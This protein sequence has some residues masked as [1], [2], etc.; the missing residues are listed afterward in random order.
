[1]SANVRGLRDNRKRKEMFT[2][3]KKQG[4][5]FAFLQEVHSSSADEHIWKNEWGNC[6]IFSHGETDA[7]G[8]CILINPKVKAV[9]VCL[10]S[11]FD[12]GRC[13]IVDVE[14]K[15]NMYTLINIYAP[16]EDKPEFFMKVFDKASEHANPDKIIAG[17]FNLVLDEKLDSF[18]RKQNNVKSAKLVR[19]YNDEMQMIDIFRFKNPDTFRFTYYRKKPNDMY[20]R[21]DN[22]L[23]NYAL[24]N[25]VEKCEIL[26]G[27]KSDHSYVVTDFKPYN[28][29][30]RGPGYWK[31]NVSILHELDNVNKIN[32]VIENAK[33]EARQND[34]CIRWEHVKAEC[35]RECKDLSRH[36]MSEIARNFEDCKIRLKR[37]T[38]RKHAS[39]CE[40]ESDTV[41]NQIDTEIAQAQSSI[42]RY[43]E[44]KAQ[45]A[46]IRSK[47]NWYENAEKGTK[48]FLG[49]EKTKSSN[50]TLRKI[51]AENGDI[52]D[53]DDEILSELKNFYGKLYSKDDHVKFQLEN[54]KGPRLTEEQKERLDQPLTI[55]ELGTSLFEMS[56][57]KAPGL[58]GLPC[59]F[60]KTFFSKLKEILFEA[61]MLSYERGVLYRSARRG[62]IS[63][64][65]KKSD[66]LLLKNWRP[67]SLCGVDCKILT[68]AIA[69][70]FKSV[71]KYIIGNQQTVYIPG[72]FIGL[73]IRK[74]IDLLSYLEKEEVP[75]LLI[76]IDFYKCFDSISHDALEGVMKYFNFGEKIIAWVRLIYNQFELCTTNNGHMSAYIR[77]QRGV[78]Q[79]CGLSGPLFLLSAELLAINFKE[80]SKIKGIKIGKN[81]EKL[82]Q[83]ADDTTIITAYDQESLDAIIDELEIIQ[84]NTGLTVN[85]DKSVI[86]RVGSLAGTNIKMPLRETL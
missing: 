37:L 2:Y 33:N 19:T 39:V 45:G 56:N 51:R 67:L 42:N 36:R 38:E 32:K 40:A 52:I 44:M 73:N 53:T 64:I 6:I 82:E 15:D 28:K 8:T 63:L 17:D 31:L 1:M 30:S 35:I 10:I 4:V 69:N 11:N 47:V 81:E 26:P 24:V 21:L 7:R 58:D 16:N 70:R 76:T 12:D 83:Y 74:L 34:A 84:N 27:Y 50:K 61:I 14:I 57:G 41:L 29:N 5:D 68:K 60:Y 59:E 72:R 23:I 75:A 25:Q 80:N 77:Q 13:N 85:Y 9:I 66:P 3:I 78:H 46:R 54:T 55:E 86:H 49:L 48:Y 71:L 22:M 62:I 20:A 43:V 79:G 18:N 65:P